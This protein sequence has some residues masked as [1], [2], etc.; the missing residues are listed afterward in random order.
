MMKNK[1]QNINI[2]Q[3]LIFRLQ[4]FQYFTTKIKLTISSPVAHLLGLK[5]KNRS[6]INYDYV[7]IIVDNEII[8]IL[9][10]LCLV[11]NFK[12]ER[13][14]SIVYLMG[15]NVKMYNGNFYYIV[16]LYYCRNSFKINYSIK[17]LNIS[18]TFPSI[19]KLFI[20]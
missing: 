13:N 16:P 4:N 8:V 10:R 9:Y 2:S 12:V 6:K 1:D 17:Y 18:L 7:K 3:L 19:K 14:L 11:Q 5:V 15:G 20:F